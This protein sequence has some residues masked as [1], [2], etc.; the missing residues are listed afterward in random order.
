MTRPKK[1]PTTKSPRIRRGGGWID[2]ELLCV[3]S[4]VR[5]ARG[6]TRRRTGLGFRVTLSGRAK[7]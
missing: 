6:S 1:T 3:S 7:R 5:G 4:A 2:D